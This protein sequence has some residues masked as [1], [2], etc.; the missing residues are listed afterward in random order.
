MQ[1]PTSTTD[2]ADRQAKIDEVYA[3]A[4]F[5]PIRSEKVTGGPLERDFELISFSACN[6]NF[7]Q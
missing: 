5:I 1:V 7:N 2:R 6:R 3:N 4:T